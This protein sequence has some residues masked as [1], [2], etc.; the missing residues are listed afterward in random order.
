[1]PEAQF[2]FCGLSE[3]DPEAA[4]KQ[5]M[6]DIGLLLDGKED[7][8]LEG[9]MDWVE[10]VRLRA[11]QDLALQH[12]AVFRNSWRTTELTQWGEQARVW[13]RCLRKREDIDLGWVAVPNNAENSGRGLMIRR[14]IVGL[15]RALHAA[16]QE[17]DQDAWTLQVGNVENCDAAQSAAADVAEA[18]KAELTTAVVLTT[19]DDQEPVGACEKRVESA[20]YGTVVDVSERGDEDIT[21]SQLRRSVAVDDIQTQ[22]L[23]IALLPKSAPALSLP[24]AVIRQN[25]TEDGG[26]DQSIE[27]SRSPGREA[28]HRRA[29]NLNPTEGDEEVH[30]SNVL[31]NIVT[32]MRSP[33]CADAHSVVIEEVGDGLP[34][35]SPEDS[36][37]TL[38]MFT[39]IQVG[40]V[41]SNVLTVPTEDDLPLGGNVPESA[42]T[43][44]P[45]THVGG[46][47]FPPLMRTEVEVKNWLKL[48]IS[49]AYDKLEMDALIAAIPR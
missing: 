36:C 18:T 49:K 15:I 14:Q 29:Q 30:P 38:P 9:I 10:N 46:V 24:G 1:M 19:A 39:E 40:A 41:T 47:T 5:V 21:I 8:V 37:D 27:D 31:V 17:D 12:P 44:S 35:H 33:T 22:D 7:G 2:R 26:E 13:S 28:S 34:R 6:V 43:V 3:W 25:A 45:F 32:L 23:D 20:V 11:L 48:S 16:L 42:T 4:H